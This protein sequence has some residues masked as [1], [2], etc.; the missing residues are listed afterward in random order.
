MAGLD[1]AI[2]QR[3]ENTACSLLHGWP[4]RSPAMTTAG[5]SLPQLPFLGSMYC[6]YAAKELRHLRTDS[7]A[8]D[9]GEMRRERR[10]SQP[11][12]SFVSLVLADRSDGMF[13]QKR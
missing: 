10:D 9:H 13:G 6:R 8:A 1:P 3:I 2:Q 4:V 12:S 7:P 5:V 11:V